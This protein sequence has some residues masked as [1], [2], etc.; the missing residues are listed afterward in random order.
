MELYIDTSK[1]EL[2]KQKYP[3]LT[4]FVPVLPDNSFSAESWR[5]RKM[6]FHIL[7]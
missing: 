5:I 3:T 1:L 2:V 7:H 4:I 6:K